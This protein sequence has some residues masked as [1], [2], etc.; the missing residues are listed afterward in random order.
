MLKEKRMEVLNVINHMEKSICK[1]CGIIDTATCNKCPIGFEFQKL[2]DR[3]L[4]ISNIKNEKVL[5]KGLDMTIKDIE[6]LLDKGVT[7]SRISKALGQ[8]V[9][10][11]IGGRRKGRSLKVFK[12]GK[13][14]RD[15]RKNIL[16]KVASIRDE[17]KR[18]RN[19]TSRKQA[20]RKKIS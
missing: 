17:T 12:N 18:G 1:P 10:K 15:T 11:I 20:K 14:K 7:R 16:T 9:S 6:R 4:E 3:L 5:S 2:G 13:R 19:N 8:D